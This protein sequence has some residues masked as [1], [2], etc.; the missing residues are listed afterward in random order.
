M[1]KERHIASPGTCSAD[2]PHRRAVPPLGRPRSLSSSC[3]CLRSRWLRRSDC[4][5]ARAARPRRC[6]DI[7]RCC[8]D[9]ALGRSRTGPESRQG[10]CARGERPAIEMRSGQRRHQPLHRDSGRPWHLS[11]RGTH[12]T[13]CARQALAGQHEVRIESRAGELLQPLVDHTDALAPCIE[14]LLF[15]VR[16]MRRDLVWHDDGGHRQAR[17]DFRRTALAL[18]G[19]LGTRSPRGTP[20][21]EL[22]MERVGDSPSRADL[23]SLYAAILGLRAVAPCRVRCQG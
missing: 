1:L 2:G 23:K 7:V 9:R 10:G 12:R 22:A 19:A 17:D 14:T 11:D 5:F 21:L 15:L 4:G 18:R 13:V 16:R 3:C 8:A 20:A 6:L